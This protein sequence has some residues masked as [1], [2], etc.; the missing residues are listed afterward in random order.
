MNSTKENREMEWRWPN[1][2]MTS[3]RGA[4]VGTSDYTV[5]NENR[6]YKV[7]HLR[8]DSGKTHVLHNLRVSSEMQA[9]LGDLIDI[10]GV[11]HVVRANLWNRTLSSWIYA[12]HRE[13]DGYACREQIPT[14]FLGIPTA[15][16]MIAGGLM[17]LFAGV[18]LALFIVGIPILLRGLNETTSG[19]WILLFRR[20]R[21]KQTMRAAG[22][23]D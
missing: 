22:F 17:G 1:I 13:H 16:M 3:I 19:I 18:V 2:K 5:E 20:N 23:P 8:D 21:A 6:I 4:I 12:Y 15:I 7:A 11:Y 10:P 14:W 9:H